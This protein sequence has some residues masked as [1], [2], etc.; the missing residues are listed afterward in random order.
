M[1]FLHFVIYF[2]HLVY[3]IL[4]FSLLTLISYLLSLIYYLLSLISYL[5]K[6]ACGFSREDGAGKRAKLKSDGM[7]ELKSE[8][9]SSFND[10]AA[11]ALQLRT[12][13]RRPTLWLATGFVFVGWKFGLS[14][15]KGARPD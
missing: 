5:K 15:A 6:T 8:L 11:H 12:C 3:F 2:I 10:H 13:R 4:L 9:V 14:A 1:Y 7:R